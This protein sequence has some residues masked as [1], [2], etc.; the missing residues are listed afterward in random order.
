MIFRNN[1]LIVH[2][3]DEKTLEALNN[4]Y[5]LKKVKNRYIILP[6]W[7][8]VINA[9]AVYGNKIKERISHYGAY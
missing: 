1:V 7:L 9:A 8:H 2:F 4:H 5:L 6:A 3:A